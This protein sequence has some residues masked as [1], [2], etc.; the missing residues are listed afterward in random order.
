MKWKSTCV[1]SERDTS[2]SSIADG[3][4]GGTSGLAFLGALGAI[5]SK[6]SWLITLTVL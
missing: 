4:G 1:G 6:S 3:G 2:I 5:F